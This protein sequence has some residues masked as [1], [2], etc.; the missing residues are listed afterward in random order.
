MKEV[1]LPKTSKNWKYTVKRNETLSHIALKFNVPVEQI[2]A[3][4]NLNKNNL[5]KAGQIIY[6]PSG[7]QI[8]AVSR[9]KFTNI[10]IV[11]KFIEA[12]NPIGEW[13]T[14]VSGYNQ[15]EIHSNNGVDISASCGQPVY[16]A[17]AGIV[18]ES[19][20]GWNGGYGNLV[21]IQ[22]SDGSSTL[23]GHLSERYIENST[24]ADKGTL[25]GAVGTTGKTTGCHL[26]FEVR[27]NRNFLLVP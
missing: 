19:A 25:I 24:Y 15:K 12:L 23:Y 13:L 5:V 14:P 9:N 18:I 22:H 16:S 1:V 11:G 17:N 6:L 8:K 2:I 27:G 3:L 10:P 4:N 26:H 20:D 7:T 21:K